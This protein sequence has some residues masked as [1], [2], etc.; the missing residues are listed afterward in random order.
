M[1]KPTAPDLELA[2]GCWLLNLTPGGLFSIFYIRDTELEYLL[3]YFLWA[4]RARNVLY[5]AEI[6]LLSS[7]WSVG[8]WDIIKSRNFETRE[9]GLPERSRSYKVV[10]V[11]RNGQRNYT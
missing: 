4:R 11:A 6:Y 7:C 1:S 9:A 10:I 8:D 3:A 2:S 5:R